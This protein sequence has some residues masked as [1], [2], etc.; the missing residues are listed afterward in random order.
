MQ[1]SSTIKSLALL[2]G[3]SLLGI[4]IFTASAPASAPADDEIHEAMEELQ[5]GM[6]T[7]RKGLGD[8]AKKDDTI[9]LLQG[10]Q[11]H[12][13]TAMLSEP[14]APKDKSGKDLALWYCGYRKQLVRVLDTLIDVEMAVHEGDAEKAKAAYKSLGQMKKAGHDE[15]L[16]DED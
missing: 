2:V 13:S 11:R 5:S 12:A 7:L 10:M 9:A 3:G 4:W 1:L 6:R 15:Y 14:H 16:V 8:P